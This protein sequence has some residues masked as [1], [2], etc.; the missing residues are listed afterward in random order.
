MRSRAGVY[1]LAGNA[2]TAACLSHATFEDISYSQ[3]APD[4]LNMDGSTFITKAGIPP[5]Y[6]E[7]AKG[8]QSS[9]NFLDDT[10]RE[11]LLLAV[12]AQI[13]EWKDSDGGLVGQWQ[14]FP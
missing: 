6:Q 5:A 4:L 11:I 2:N 14:R 7:T 10:I 3:F 8:R 12:V 9:Y 1:E 13:V